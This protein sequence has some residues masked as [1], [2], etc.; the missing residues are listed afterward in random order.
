MKQLTFFPTPYPEECYYSIISRYFARSGSLSHKATTFELFDEAQSLSA[1]IYLPRR[2]ELLEEWLGKETI[3]SRR[4]LAE[5]HTAYSYFS[6]SF[7]D[8]LIEKL[9]RKIESGDLDRSFEK[10]MIQKSKR[11]GWQT[12][13]RYCPKCVAEDIEKYGE[14]YWH[15]LPQLVGVEYCPKHGCAIQNSNIKLARAT[16]AFIPASHALRDLQAVED[17]VKK[18][19]KEK[20]LRVAKDSEWLLQ[21][22]KQL[23]GSRTIVKKYMLLLREKGLTTVQGIRYKDRFIDEFVKYHGA[24]FLMQILPKTKNPLYWLQYVFVSMSKHVTPLQHVLMMEF[25]KGTVETFFQANPEEDLYGTGPWPCVNKI[26]SHYGTDGAEKVNNS[27]MNGIAMAQFQCR[28]CG[29]KYQRNDPQ[30]KFEDYVSR[31]T[32]LDYGE[33][34]YQKLRECLEEKNLNVTDTARNMK[35]TTATVK[36]RAKEAGI[37][38]LNKKPSKTKEEI[39]LESRRQVE[40]LL[41]KQSEVSLKELREKL[42][43]ATNWLYSN[44]Y[45]WLKERVVLERQKSY[46]KDIEKEQ[47]ELL[48]EAYDTIKENGDKN[49]RIT[50]GWLCTTAGL[51]DSEI[52]SRGTWLLEMK[53]FLDEVIE[54]KE[55]WLT[56][57][58]TEIA[59]ECKKKGQKIR[60]SDIKRE[61]SLKP[62]TY[63]KYADFLENLL[64]ELNQ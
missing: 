39:S 3:L 45:L 36:R 49:R 27:Y 34:W 14:T 59:D 51:S 31:A 62:N 10:G 21:N 33:L 1:F 42:P 46:W 22:G 52:K 26:C 43:E 23:G 4:K 7:S 29:M 35:A 19:Y 16:G 17:E 2:L 15:R 30:K 44:E 47:L 56:R 25:L 63:K 11:G 28:Y 18:K 54:S 53:A 24:D 60:I 55:V 5:E 6:V 64:Q 57:R 32:I 61:M 13:L 58:I 20:Y 8:E 9:E 40:A 50:L 38:I 37:T 48:K 12:H 41:E